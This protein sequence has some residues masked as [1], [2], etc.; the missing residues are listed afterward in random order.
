[1]IARLLVLCPFLL[2]AK[3]LRQRAGLH[4]KGLG[5][6]ACGRKFEN[7][8]QGVVWNRGAEREVQRGQGTRARASITRNPRKIG[9]S[10]FLIE[11]LDLL[12][13]RR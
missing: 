8:W 2:V 12:G 7:E 11:D 4:L 3:L 5:Q 13:L 1:M 9:G 6:G 10:R